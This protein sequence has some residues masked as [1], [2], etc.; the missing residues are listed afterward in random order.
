MGVRA[1]RSVVQA[2]RADSR[3]AGKWNPAGGK[4]GAFA[5][6]SNDGLPDPLHRQAA[7]GVA[8]AGG[9]IINPTER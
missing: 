6:S 8:E 2:K 5:K 4:L 7:V 9:A 1:C 3:R